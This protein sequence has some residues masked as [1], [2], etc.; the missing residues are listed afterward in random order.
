M[1][2]DLDGKTDKTQ[3]KLDSANDRMKDMMSKL[4]DKSSNACVYIICLVIL[5]GIASVVYNMAMK[6]K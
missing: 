4:N 6:N 3:T 5:L 1:L 2:N